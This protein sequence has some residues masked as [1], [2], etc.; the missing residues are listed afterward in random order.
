MTY[1]DVGVTPGFGDGFKQV[2]A[3]TVPVQ[4]IT[5]ASG[6]TPS[7][8]GNVS[9]VT[10]TVPPGTVWKL[11]IASAVDQAVIDPSA[12]PNTARFDNITPGPLFDT[13]NSGTTP[14][15]NK[16][17]P[18]HK[19]M[20]M[21]IE[22]AKTATISAEDLWRAFNPAFAGNT[23][24]V[25]L[26]APTSGDWPL[27]RRVDVTR[28]A[29]RWLGR[30]YNTK[31]FPFIAAAGFNTVTFIS[32]P[33]NPSKSPDTDMSNA[34]QWEAEAFAGRVDGDSTAS[35]SKVHF[36]QGAASPTN[37]TIYTADL[38]TDL[39]ALYFRFGVRV[40]SRYDG[41]PNF[42]PFAN[43]D[44]LAA[45]IAFGTKNLS[46]GF[47]T[48]KRIF[49]PARVAANAKV[50]K[51]KLLIC[52][53]ITTA[54]DPKVYAILSGSPSAPS[55]ARTDLLV[56]ANEPWHQTAGL[57]EQLTAS[58]ELTS[59]PDKTIRPQI[60]PDP[61]LS[62]TALDP[63]L[64][65]TFQTT[66]GSVITSARSIG[67]PIGAT[68]DEVTDAPLFANTCFHVRMPQNRDTAGNFDKSLDWVM[69]KLQF[70]RTIDSTMYDPTLG[71]APQSPLT[72]GTWVELLPSSD[73]FNSSAGAVA[74]TDLVFQTDSAVSLRKSA[75][76]TTVI[77]LQPSATSGGQLELWALLMQSIVDAAGLPGEVYI[78]LVSISGSSVNLTATPPNLAQAEHLYLLEVQKSTDAPAAGTPNSPTWL[79]RL[80]PPAT[81][82]S[83]TNA[84]YRV[85]RL[86]NTINRYVPS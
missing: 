79:D 15:G 10:I 76:P 61:I 38:S 50:A 60:G 27:V 62:G 78:G 9:G 72:D 29:W 40:Y 44:S 36:L 30:P 47:T 82:T 67:T 68:F 25:S 23:L 24:S 57:A 13:S 33:L 85:V 55:V 1:S 77:T 6:S 11:S 18:V 20:Q 59:N 35:T 16:V 42:S 51:P 83:P 46:D 49:V 34:L 64:A 53:P 80:F 37:V 48:W 73:H 31:P 86:S 17:V 41:L 39:R 63:T 5:G 54:L 84:A 14:A 21:L 74:V 69:A 32:D 66:N 28:Q 2:Q 4:V 81:S 12:N 70:S 52:I 8:V 19:P 7:V 26:T 75:D 45:K 71:G 58:I 43:G 3:N 22:V 65:A 56:I